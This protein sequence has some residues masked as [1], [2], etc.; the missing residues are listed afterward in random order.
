[1]EVAQFPGVVE[2]APGHLGGIG[3]TVE[4]VVSGMLQ[5][6]FV[7]GMALGILMGLGLSAFTRLFRD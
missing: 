7:L 2:Y 3:M 6:S 1:M 4:Q 5:A